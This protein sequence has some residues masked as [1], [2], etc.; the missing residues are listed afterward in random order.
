MKTIMS[1]LLVVMTNNNGIKGT[2]FQILYIGFSASK[3]R[4]T[5]TCTMLISQYLPQT[6]QLSQFST[7]PIQ[8][9]RQHNYSEQGVWWEP[10]QQ[11]VKCKATSDD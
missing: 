6:H 2:H 8:K 4:D 7:E 1:L 11:G 10:A 3:L 5:I 9:C